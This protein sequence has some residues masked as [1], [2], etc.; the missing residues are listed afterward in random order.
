MFQKVIK[1]TNNYTGRYVKVCNY[2]KKN[3]RHIN[4][5]P[6]KKLWHPLSWR[7]GILGYMFI[8]TCFRINHRISPYSKCIPLGKTL[9]YTLYV[10]LEHLTLYITKVFHKAVCLVHYYLLFMLMYVDCDLWLLMPIY[11][12]DLLSAPGIWIKMSH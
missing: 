10:A 5:K 9:Y 2:F 7:S 4:K 1:L 8:W 12:L 6:I 11:V 3:F